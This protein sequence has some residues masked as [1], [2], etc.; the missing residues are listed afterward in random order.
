MVAFN[1]EKV[2]LILFQ[3]FLSEKD[4]SKDSG[5]VSN[6]AKKKTG[7]RKGAKTQRVAKSLSV[8]LSL[9]LYGSFF[10]DAG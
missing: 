8:L 5:S 1:L 3:P 6:M 10:R 4:V 7:S 2:C 9:R